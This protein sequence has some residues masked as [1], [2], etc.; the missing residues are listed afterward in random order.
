MKVSTLLHNPGAGAEKYNKEQL[1]SKVQSLGYEC[2]YLSTKKKGWK[3]IQSDTDFLIIAGGDGTVR[4]VVKNLLDKKIIRKRLPLALLPLGTANNISKTLAIEGEPEELAKSW[5]EKNIKKIDVGFIEGLSEPNFFLEGF[6]YGIFPLLMEKM[7]EEDEK[8]FISLDQEVKYSL[9]VLHD[10]IVSYEAQ[11]LQM[12]V[13]GNDCSGKYLMAEI[14][15]IRSIGPNLL[16][17]PD[18]D[19]GDGKLEVVLVPENQRGELADYV[20]NKLNGIENSFVFNSIK[21]RAVRMH[22]NERHF[23]L[24]DELIWIDEPA[25]IKIEVFDGLL[26]FFVPGEQG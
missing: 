13:D 21:A 16:L 3:E 20:M 10:M 1:I 7:R 6:G 12:E 17:A 2:R 15:N 19:P 18:A 24:D 8:S 25:E 14:M 23:H 4:K 11:D 5:T 9:Q 26:K 22:C